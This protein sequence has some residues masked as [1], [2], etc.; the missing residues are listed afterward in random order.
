[1]CV[2][3]VHRAKRRAHHSPL[4]D[5]SWRQFKQNQPRMNCESLRSMHSIRPET[6]RHCRGLLSVIFGV[7]LAPVRGGFIIILVH[8]L[9]RSW[10]SSYI[11]M[12][13]E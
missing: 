6:P 4:V 11:I 8:I 10:S 13:V 2:Q 7:P 3:Q 1:M 5:G 12:I 9:G